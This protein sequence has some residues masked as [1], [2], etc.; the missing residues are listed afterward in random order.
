M[1][2]TPVERSNPQSAIVIPEQSSSVK[3]L[4]TAWER[5][6]FNPSIDKALDAA[7]RGNQDAAIISLR[8][9]L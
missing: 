7:L 4:C 2:N 5:I 9:T 3:V 8:E 6:R 1:E